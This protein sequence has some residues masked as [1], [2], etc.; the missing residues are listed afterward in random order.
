MSNVALAKAK[1]AVTPK[2]KF[3]KKVIQEAEKRF[4]EKEK[5][6]QEAKAEFLKSNP[7]PTDEQVIEEWG[8]NYDKIT[9][10]FLLWNMDEKKWGWYWP[11]K[12]WDDY[13]LLRSW[14]DYSPVVGKENEILRQNILRPINV[15]P[16]RD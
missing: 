14:P 10:P 6:R 15:E 13:Y 8:W 9:Q 5:L 12:G 2:V 1:L 11:E 7:E 3:S 16:P 4:Q